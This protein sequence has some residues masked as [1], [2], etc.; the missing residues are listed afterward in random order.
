MEK[1]H[2][3]YQK[4]CDVSRV[5]VHPDNREKTGVVPVDAHDLLLQM[6]VQGFVMS[7]VDAL[8]TEIPPDTE[9]A[10]WRKYNEN[11]A[12]KSDG[13]LP[14]CCGSE[15]ELMTARGSHT[16][17]A[18]RIVALADKV[19][20]KGIH[21]A[22]CDDDGFISKPK[23]IGAKPSFLEPTASGLPYTVVRWQLTKACPKLFEV[24]SRTGNAMHGVHRRQ[25]SVQAIKRVHAL[26]DGVRDDDTIVRQA[27]LNQ[28]VGYD[29]QA[30]ACLAFVKRWASSS[31]SDIVV[32]L[33]NFECTLKAKRMVSTAELNALSNLDLF[34]APR[35]VV[36]ML[37]ASIAAPNLFVTHEYANL[38][39]NTD[40][41]TITGGGRQRAAAIEANNLMGEARKFVRAYTNFT[42]SDI[43]SILS[44]MEIRMVMHIHGKK[45]RTRKQY[46][47]VLHVCQLF[48]IEI[49]KKQ[50]AINKTLPKWQVL[51]PLLKQQKQETERTPT[52]VIQV[53]SDGKVGTDTMIEH[54]FE[55]DAIITAKDGGP[56]KKCFTIV[57][58][59]GE[60]VQV[61]HVKNY[62]TLTKQCEDVPKKEPIV[63]VPRSSMLSKY[64]K[65]KI[66]VQLKVYMYDPDKSPVMDAGIMA[67]AQRGIIISAI[68]HLFRTKSTEHHVKIIHRKGVH[69]IK[70]LDEDAI[71]LVVL[72]QN[73]AFLDDES[74]VSLL[75]NGVTRGER[76][77]AFEIGKSTKFA[78]AKVRVGVDA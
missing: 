16:T 47:S 24:L 5:G 46:A 43:V 31:E 50:T 52:G 69:A 33:E 64:A 2:L 76:I 21:Q 9:G 11:L 56:I 40:F 73:I 51:E 35:Y 66:P 34:E 25:T 41:S 26:R 77:G 44:D 15:L 1:S 3:S 17:A 58:A 63:T 22:L 36:A 6:F 23:I 29:Q 67:A 19:K 60:L 72:T 78:Y 75:K 32:D 62:N 59:A 8:A 45:I 20:V 54:G 4:T 48:Y 28:P 55:N 49:E 68:V 42:H 57:C 71:N 18:T 39:T 10:A 70:T 30:K 7:E 65:F 12:E 37:K 74:Q 61:R 27:S 38:W 53:T 13:L 14:E